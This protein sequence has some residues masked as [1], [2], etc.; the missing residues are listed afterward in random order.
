MLIDA[1]NSF[2]MSAFS[3]L[4]LCQVTYVVTRHAHTHTH[5]HV[6]L[7]LFVHCSCAWRV[8]KSCVVVELLTERTRILSESESEISFFGQQAYSS[9][10]QLCMQ[11]T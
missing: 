2:I 9:P 4:A 6:H 8:F 11:I 3:A 1:T 5:T 7:Y 10:K